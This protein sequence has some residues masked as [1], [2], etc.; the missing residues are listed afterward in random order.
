[1]KMRTPLLALLLALTPISSAA[2]QRLLTM[3]G[4]ERYSAMLPRL[5]QLQRDL[6]G[7]VVWAPDSRSVVFTLSGERLSYDL[8]TGA[9]T[10]AAYAEPGGRGR[11]G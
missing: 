2:Q 11:R 7:A 10:A 1:M 3:P 6:S 5:T 4:Y 8:T 9:T